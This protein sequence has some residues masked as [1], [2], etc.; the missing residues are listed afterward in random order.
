MRRSHLKFAFRMAAAVILIVVPM[1]VFAWLSHVGGL[2]GKQADDA[3]MNGVRLVRLDRLIGALV[4]LVGRDAA[5][6]AALLGVGGAL[7]ASLVLGVILAV[8]TLRA[9]RPE[10]VRGFD[11]RMVKKLGRRWSDPNED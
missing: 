7:L 11:I 9:P 8:W 6:L 3:A 4:P 5:P 1:S 10:Q 2:R